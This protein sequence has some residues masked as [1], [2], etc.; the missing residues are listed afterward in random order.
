MYLQNSPQHPSSLAYPT[1]P[2]PQ[3][4]LPGYSVAEA[5]ASV[6]VPS[7]GLTSSLAGTLSGTAAVAATPFSFL[8]LLA[9]AFV[10]WLLFR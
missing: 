9:L 3:A 7:P 4:Q 5:V 8:P 2:I 10:L 1:P 6:N